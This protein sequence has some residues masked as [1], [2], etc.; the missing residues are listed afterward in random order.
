MIDNF[1]VIYISCW[2]DRKCYL[3]STCQLSEQPWLHSSALYLAL[4]LQGP[5]SRYQLFKTYPRI[6]SSLFLSGFV[7]YFDF[8]S[9]NSEFSNFQIKE[10]KYLSKLIYWFR[11]LAKEQLKCLLRPNLKNL[12]RGL[13]LGR[14]LNL[15]GFT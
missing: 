15:I 2:A 12:S 4:S 5:K 9:L 11:R 13:N 8:N 10:K 3:S 7:P 14:G 1:L 6:Y